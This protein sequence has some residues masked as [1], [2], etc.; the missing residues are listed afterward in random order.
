MASSACILS[1][2]TRHRARWI[3]AAPIPTE[4]GNLVAHVFQGEACSIAAD[5]ST[6][7]LAWVVGDIGRGE[8]VPVRIHSECM[9]SEVFGSLKC[10]CKQQLD[11]AMD[12]MAKAGRGVL[13]YLRQEGRGI[14][15]GAKI[16]AYA[17]QAAGMD[18]VE[19]NRHQGLP[20]DARVYD[21]VVDILDHLGVRSL[22]LLTNNPLKAEAMRELGLE[23]TGVSPVVVE[24]NDHSRDYLVCKR[25][26]MAHRL[27]TYDGETNA[28]HLTPFQRPR[29][30]GRRKG[31]IKKLG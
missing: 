16:Q 4:R 31:P 29:A 15:L 18:T 7:H 3:S 6:E 20:D 17:L 21:V 23:V 24:P 26:R 30:P 2:P 8:D 27:P 5:L 28:S 1:Q 25:T 14:G 22:R 10:D 9:T 19:A 13:I 12:Q 11:L